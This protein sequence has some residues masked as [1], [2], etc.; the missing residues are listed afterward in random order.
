MTVAEHLG[1]AGDLND[2]MRAIPHRQFLMWQ[3][4]IKRGWNQPTR[5]DHYL[6]Q[7]AQNICNVLGGKVSL[8]EMQISFKSELSSKS[9][10]WTNPSPEQTALSQGAWLTVMGVTS[11]RNGS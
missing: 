5:S 9:Q 7:I 8:D 6:M 3:E 10:D 1:Y 2:L 4:R 11:D